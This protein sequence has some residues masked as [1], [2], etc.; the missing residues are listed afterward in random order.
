VG[1]PEDQLAEL[2]KTLI[3]GHLIRMS[4]EGVIVP[5]IAALYEFVQLTNS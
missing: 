2:S 5:D 3:R 4:R 1:V